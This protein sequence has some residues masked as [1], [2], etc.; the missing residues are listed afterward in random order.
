[1]MAR[2]ML[3]GKS[4]RRQAGEQQRVQDMVWRV[5]AC[6]PPLLE[7][8]ATARAMAAGMNLCSQAGRGR[9]TQAKHVLFCRPPLHR[10]QET[11]GKAMAAGMPLSR[12]AGERQRAQTTASHAVVY[13]LSRQQ[14]MVA[15][16]MAT[17]HKQPAGRVQAQAQARH[18]VMCPLLLPRHP[19]TLA[20]AMA[21][22]MTLSLIAP[23]ITPMQARRWGNWEALT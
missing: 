19:G 3:A 21:A 9:R 6:P 2:A 11:R 17:L 18:T 22:G 14:E 1:M 23:C 5:V 15:R 16:A 20:R 13:P 10:N 4:I 7:M 12:P 8:Q